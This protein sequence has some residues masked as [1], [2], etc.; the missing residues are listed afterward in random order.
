[1]I[2]FL[3]CLSSNENFYEYYVKSIQER[4]VMSLVFYGSP[5]MKKISNNDRVMKIRKEIG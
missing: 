4:M 2:K 3:V 5:N 1:M